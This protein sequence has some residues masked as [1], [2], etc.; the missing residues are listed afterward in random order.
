MDVGDDS[1]RPMEWCRDV[2]PRQEEISWLEIRECPLPASAL[3]K[4]L[5]VV[6]RPSLPE[7]TVVVWFAT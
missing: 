5:E 4:A 6:R 2:L 7:R 3:L 1:C